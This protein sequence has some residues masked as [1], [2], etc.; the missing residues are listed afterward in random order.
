MP[1]LF[2]Y[3]AKDAN[4]VAILR[5]GKYRKEWQLIKWD[6]DSDTFQMGQWLKNKMVFPSYCSISP[7]GNY[8]FYHYWEGGHYS[9][10]AVFSKLPNFTAEYYGKWNTYYYPCSFTRD[11][12][13]VHCLEEQFAQR[14]STDLDLVIRKNVN[15]DDIVSSGYIGY[16]NSNTFL[17]ANGIME[18]DETLPRFCGDYKFNEYYEKHATFVDTRQ[19]V[20]TIKEGIIYA[21]GEILLDTT[22]HKFECVNPI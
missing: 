19:R 18:L 21:N 8:F 17:N 3:K 11:G 22:N 6:I 20:I 4:I 10:D 13:G 14:R 7:N 15:P 16:R 2:L 1:K 9:E 12:K 5:R